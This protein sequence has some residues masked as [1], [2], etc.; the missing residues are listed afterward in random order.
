MTSIIIFSEVRKMLSQTF[1]QEYDWHFPEKVAS[2]D[3]LKLTQQHQIPPLIASLLYSRGLRSLEELK[4]FIKPSWEDLHD[5][6]LL[7]DMDIAVN[8]L[9]QAQH[10]KEKVF[11][12]GDYDVDG[13]TSV[14][15]VSMFLGRLGFELETY[16]PD[17]YEE[18][19]G[20]SPE[21]IE[22]AHSSNCTLIITLDCGTKDHSLIMDANKKGIDVIVCDHHEP[23]DQLPKALAL[24]NPKRKDCTYPFK[25]LSGCGVGFKLLHAFSQQNSIPEEIV[26]SFLDLLALS[27][28]ADIVPIVDENRAM[29]ALGL[30]AMNETLRPAFQQMLLTGG[31]EKPIL[32]IS[33]LV[34]TFA[35]RINAAGRMEHASLAVHL[36][37][38]EDRIERE[39]TAAYIEDLNTSRRADDRSITNEA[40]DL[41]RLNNE[42]VSP[43]TIVYRANWNQGVVG[44]VASRLIENYH[45]PTIVLTENNGLL[46][47]SARSVPGF[48]IH[49]GLEACSDL[50][51]KF[52]GHEMAA[53]LS[54]RKEQL[55]PFKQKFR[56]VVSTIIQSEQK[57]E[58]YIDAEIDLDSFKVEE[59]RWLKRMQPF[60][61]GNMSPVFLARSVHLAKLPKIIGKDRSHLQLEIKRNT[62][63]SVK[64][65]AFGRAKD[66]KAI[67]RQEAIDILFTL[68]ENY[69]KGKTSLQFH[70]KDWRPV[71]ETF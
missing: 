10:G 24:L 2:E 36:L 44:I 20:L 56:D 46:T 14:A 62:G 28:A 71:A 53:G 11:V 64:C 19:Y 55:D 34:F 59:F 60:G 30:S 3:W 49:D 25:G 17:R 58:I 32:T 16:L 22:C 23:G 42:E 38:T 63:N 1:V 68:E 6:F 50:L 9:V 45:R 27:I 5:P 13:T 33:D 47:G 15:M 40:L 26:A 66:R 48:N 8:R 39:E 52:G 21:A 7:K 65:M 18:G 29:A 12:F 67:A 37:S 61:P 69:W 51:E 54:L 35:P 4:K 43:A 41:I 70:L 31:V 57:E